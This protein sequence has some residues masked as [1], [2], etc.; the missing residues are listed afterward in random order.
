MLVCPTA[1]NTYWHNYPAGH[2]PRSRAVPGV[3]DLR[4][5]TTRYW[6][7]ASTAQELHRRHGKVDQ[8]ILSVL[9][10]MAETRPSEGLAYAAG[11][12]LA[13]LGH[14]YALEGWGAA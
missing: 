11:G 1:A 13:S 6:R 8:Y 14:G 9:A 12:T 2:P 7:Y 10:R 4:R 3:V 5:E